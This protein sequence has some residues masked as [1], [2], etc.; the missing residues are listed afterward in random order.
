MYFR[1]KVL[2]V[3]SGSVGIGRLA[4]FPPNRRQGKLATWFFWVMNKY[5]LRSD[6]SSNEVICF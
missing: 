2:V 6:L 3:P 5:A 4:E 1:C